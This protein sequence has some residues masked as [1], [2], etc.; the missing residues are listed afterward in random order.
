MW[1]AVAPDLLAKWSAGLNLCN[2]KRYRKVCRETSKILRLS[3]SKF[4]VA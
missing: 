1:G 3:G 4:A 2:R